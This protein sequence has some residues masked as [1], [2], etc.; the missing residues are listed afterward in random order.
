MTLVTHPI[1]NRIAIAFDLD[2][3]LMPSTYDS[4]LK[5]L[6][7]DP[8]AFR[9]DRYRPLLD[10]GWESIP[11][12]C[13]TLVDESRRR[14]AGQKITREF[15]ET[16]SA[17]LDPFPGVDVMFDRLKQTAKAIVP[18]IEVEFYLITSGM[19]QVARHT[20]IAKHFTHM[21]GCEFHFDVSG[22]VCC[23]KRSLTYSEKPRYLYY[24]S[25]GGEART[26]DRDI[27]FVYDDIAPEDLHVP[28]ECVIYVGDGTSDLPCFAML[29]QRGGTSIGVLKAGQT[30]TEWQ[31][32]RQVSPGQ[33]I[34]NLAP[35]DYSERSELM[36]S[37]EL[38]VESISKHIALRQLSRNDA[39]E[40]GA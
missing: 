11:A 14:P 32:D 30:A 12:K 38:A 4:L 5:A 39:I 29:N 16:F 37:L 9:R 22:E 26:R 6:D 33:R 1:P 27:T 20:R 21:W 13:F 28:L 3:T 35:P 36:Q 19:V 8:Q 7:L 15:I 25:K 17:T 34:F 31:R 2:D 18:D 24:L 40:V 10:Q 23:L